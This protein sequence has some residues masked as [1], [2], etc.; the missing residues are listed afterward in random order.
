M[1]NIEYSAVPSD[2][3]LHHEVEVIGISGSQAQAQGQVVELAIH[4]AVGLQ[5]Q[6]VPHLQVYHLQ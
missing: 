2:R 5:V 1:S 6:G 3:S 4:R